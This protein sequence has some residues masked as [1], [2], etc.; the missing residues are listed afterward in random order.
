M[1]TSRSLPSPATGLPR[2]PASPFQRAVPITPADR[3][4]ACVD[5]FPVHSAFPVIQAGRHPRLHFRGLLGL[6]SRYGPLDRSTAQGDLC[7]EASARSGCPAEPLVS[8][9]INRQLSGWNLPPLV[10]RAVGAHRIIQ[11]NDELISVGIKLSK[12]QDEHIAEIFVR[13]NNQGTRLGQADFD[14]APA[15]AIPRH[16]C[17]TKSCR[18]RCRIACGRCRRVPA[19]HGSGTRSR[20]IAQ[21]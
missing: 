2:L 21:G 1:A 9:Q 11:A 20:G 10:I 5:C 7:H 19:A 16:H 4:G 6:H 3:T 12:A 15:R 17:S 14:R 13:I 8:Y 18:E